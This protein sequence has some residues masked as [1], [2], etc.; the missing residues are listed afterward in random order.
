MQKSRRLKKPAA[1][2]PPVAAAPPSPGRLWLFRV[3]TLLLAPIF[4]VLLE[5]GLRLASYGYDAA[6][7]LPAPGGGA[8]RTN[9]RF[10][11][12][13]FPAAIARTPLGLR[14]KVP[15]PPGTYR[16]AVLGE[17]AAQGYPKPAFAMP[18][19]LEVLLEHDRP[20]TDVEV[21]NLGITA[22]NSH[23]IRDVAKETV[24]SIQPDLIV[25]YAGNNEVVGPFGPGTV[26]AGFSPNL[27][28]IRTALWVR[29]FRIA[30]LIGAVIPSLG[31]G[32][33]P[34]GGWKGMEMFVE[35][36]VAEDDPRLPAVY[37]HFR[38]NLEDI[39]ETARSARV[40]VVISTVAANLRDCAPFKSLHGSGLSEADRKR[41]QESFDAG[42]QAQA[43]GDCRR[44][45]EPLQA[46]AKIDDGYAEAHFRLGQ[47]LLATGDRA[48]ADAAF[49]R[50]R[51]A[52]TLRFRP[53]RPINETIRAVAEAA[54]ARDGATLRFVD[55]EAA[56]AAAAVDGIPGQQ[57][58]YEHVH[59]TFEG[60]YVLARALRDAILPLLP[61]GDGP[62]TGDPLDPRRAASLVGYTPLEEY[63]SY[64]QVSEK[65]L[66]HP[67]FT[68][69]FNHAEQQQA[70][71]RRLSALAET[72]TADV[73]RDAERQAAEAVRARPDDAD[74]RLA[75]SHVLIATKQYP[76][77]M[78]QL[79]A[80]LERNPDHNGCL[81]RMAGVLELM[82]RYDEANRYVQRMID[83]APA[84]VAAFD[85]RIRFAE[86]LAHAGKTREALSQLEGLLQEQGADPELAFKLNE[87][88]A[89]LH[90]QQGNVPTAVRH[91]R[92]ALTAKPDDLRGHVNLAAA[93]LHAGDTAGA[94]AEAAHVKDR[95]VEDDAALAFS[96]GRV[97][98]RMGDADQAQ[99][100]F[101]KSI[102]T[103]SQ[104]L[105]GRQEYVAFMAAAGR[106]REGASF[107]R[108][109]LRRHPKLL[110]GRATLA[111]ALIQAGDYAEAAAE[112]RQHLRESPDDVSSTLH[113]ARLL[114][115]APNDTLRN[116]R[117]ALGLAE[118]ITATQP[119]LVPAVDV[120]AMAYAET[121]DY[122]RAAEIQQ[123]LAASAPPQY[124]TEQQQ[125]VALYRSRRPYRLPPGGAR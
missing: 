54:A 79:T 110:A 91:Y 69:Q 76:V 87:Q 71:K 5:G 11:V 37:S 80:G 93:L 8:V 25:V 68:G 57:H 1:A 98:G 65:L 122:E 4:F 38:R 55:G 92:T 33:A 124:Q 43:A 30:Q 35:K 74:V 100:L 61:P 56:L 108:E 46:A 67:P 113:L 125:R 60:N 103:D 48:G 112:L 23:V 49:R 39:I 99:A 59:L 32:S 17:S 109:L 27:S 34:A 123:R 7:F 117:E 41:W 72:L 118:A 115:A 50:A 88:I 85:E 121:G 66:G 116:G 15:K 64:R 97:Y 6:L 96:L 58:L 95:L 3:A 52:D 104:Q 107:L 53:A 2:P 13:F 62:P 24:A 20:R 51:D 86:N 90:L 19:V 21:V 26:F 28:T 29:R 14:I 16:I 10:S 63:T 102:T 73:V 114:A 47:C 75:Y 89:T 78:A 40:P 101:E 119:N 9:P 77:A 120:L 18:R 84:H 31:G 82:K 105:E 22:I 81:E 45:I 106:A 70:I 94:A 12:R 83:L 36:A 44:A 42:T 111:A